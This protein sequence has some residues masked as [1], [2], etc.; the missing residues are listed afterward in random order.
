M[1]L[2]PDDALARRR[3]RAL[4][5]ARSPALGPRP[6]GVSK[7]AQAAVSR[8]FSR[9]PAS[10]ANGPCGAPIVFARRRE[11]T[12]AAR[13][14]QTK[15]RVGPLSMAALGPVLDLLTKIRALRGQPSS[16]TTGAR[17]A[18]RASGQSRFSF[19]LRWSAS[20]RPRGPRLP[21]TTDDELARAS[22]ARPPGS[23]RPR[24]SASWISSTARASTRGAAVT[25]PLS[26]ALSLRE[27]YGERTPASTPP[28]DL[29]RQRYKRRRRLLFELSRVLRLA[30]RA[31][32]ALS[33]CSR[34]RKRQNCASSWRSCGAAP[35]TLPRA[36]LRLL[37]RARRGSAQPSSRELLRCAR[38]RGARRRQARRKP[39]VLLESGAETQQIAECA[40]AASYPA[41]SAHTERRVPSGRSVR[42]L[43]SQND[44]Q[45]RACGVVVRR[46]GVWRW[47]SPKRRWPRFGC[48]ASFAG[49]RGARCSKRRRMRT[50]CGCGLPPAWV[51]WARRSKRRG[52]ARLLLFEHLGRGA[53][54]ARA[55]LSIAAAHAAVGPRP[56]EARESRR[57]GHFLGPKLRLTSAGRA[58]RAFRAFATSPRATAKRSSTSKRAPLAARPPTAD[59]ELRCAA[60]LPATWR[61]SRADPER[62]GCAPAPKPPSTRALEWWGARA[63]AF[64]GATQRRARRPP[65]LGGAQEPVPAP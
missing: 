32:V 47:V 39:N 14:S 2:P 58:Y 5:A 29:V 60:R 25:D 3:A 37:E 35:A 19:S 36:R 50:G 28:E 9:P 57:R 8:D 34:A 11:L 44:E 12:D 7:R 10:A 49:A 63:R 20:P 40:S 4:F 52:G 1:R 53:E 61:S 24:R 41:G 31:G 65:F 64:G 55:V 23:A 45:A 33:P 42:G 16:G 43:L 6:R 54:A 48:R 59:D 21:L 46:A 51:I 15:L 27:A 22:D 62:R 56:V 38:P 30:R 18:R 26:L 17:R 13:S